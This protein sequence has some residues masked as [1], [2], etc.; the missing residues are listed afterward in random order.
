MSA[1]EKVRLVRE[2]SPEYGLTAALEAVELPKS[3][4]YYQQ[5]RVSYADKHQALRP[6]VEQVVAEHPDYGIRRVTEELQQGH[7]QLV[8]R[9][10]VARLLGLWDLALRRSTHAPPPSGLQQVIAA[11]GERANLLPGLSDIGL[12]EVLVTDFTELPYA[13]G[14]HKAYLMPL[15]DHTG[16]LAVGWA[17]GPSD[18]S[19]L[20]LAAWKHAK[21][22]LRRYRVPTRGLIVH[23]DQDAVYTG[24]AWTSQLLLKDGVRLSYALHGPQDNPEIESF[25]GRFKTENESLLL[26]A[27]DLDQLREVVGNQI[28]YYNTQR[29][30]SSLGYLSPRDY[31]RQVR[32]K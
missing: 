17:V 23:H 27:A 24:Y 28:C 26:D 25:F 18:N 9:K 19:Q 11:S 2:A 14:Q 10:V 16:K 8:N 32:A 21:A 7:Q 31:L 4:W 1:E 20:A 12:F 3:T 30:H 29:R 6:L 15:L 22:T 5:E 13:G